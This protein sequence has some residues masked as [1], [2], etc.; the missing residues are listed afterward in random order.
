MCIRHA[1]SVWV[2]RNWNQFPSWL[3]SSIRTRRNG[4]ILRAQVPVSLSWESSKLSVISICRVIDFFFLYTLKRGLLRY[5]IGFLS[6]PEHISHSS[7]TLEVDL[8][9]RVGWRLNNFQLPVACYKLYWF[10]GGT[11]WVVGGGSSASC[12]YI[13]PHYVAAHPATVWA[14]ACG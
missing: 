14:G 5:R 9:A 8:T 7:T 12:K 3:L 13:L 1:M 6:L 11:D 2:M 4:L 10:G